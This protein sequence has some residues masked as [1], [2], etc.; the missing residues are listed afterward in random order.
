MRLWSGPSRR[1]GR[2]EAHD[3]RSGY[4]VLQ[5]AGNIDGRQALHRGHRRV[6]RRLY[7][8]RA[9]HPADTVPRPRHGSTIGAHNG[10]ARHADDGRHGARVPGRPFPHA[11]TAHEETVHVVAVL[12]VIADDPRGGSPDFAD[13]RLQPGQTYVRHG[14]AGSSVH[15]RRPAQVPQLH[16][17][18]LFHRAVDG[19]QTFLYGL[20]TDRA[21]DVRR[22]MGKEAVERATSQRGTSQVYR[23]PVK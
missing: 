12:P 7:I 18:V 10:L 20:R 3:S 2:D 23:R 22:Q 11:H 19:P 14:R 15:R 1:T 4:P 6:E 21:A 13:A 17:Q 8:R 5:G 16:V 9:S